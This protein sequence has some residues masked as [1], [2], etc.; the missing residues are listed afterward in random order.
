[1]FGS[2]RRPMLAALPL[3]LALA[4][5]ALPAH[6]DNSWRD[7]WCARGEGMSVVVDWA[8]APAAKPA[9]SQGGTHL[10]RCLRFANVSFDSSREGRAAPF[11]DIGVSVTFSNELV[12]SVNGIDSDD[13]GGDWM[14]AGSR[15]TLAWDMSI[16]DPTPDIPFFIASLTVE[17]PTTFSVEPQWGDPPSTR[18][19]PSPAPST[20]RPATTPT[21]TASASRPA[22]E[23]TARPDQPS[24]RH[25]PT[26]PRTRSARP[27][28]PRPTQNPTRAPRPAPSPTSSPTPTPSL[29]A[30]PSLT[31]SPSG[32]ATAEAKDVAMAAPPSPTPSAVWGAEHA[33]RAATDAP[34]GLPGWVLPAGIAGVLGIGGALAHAIVRARREGEDFDE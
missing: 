32:T 30:S 8:Q 3:T 11:D 4:P 26:A 27:T 29:E 22:P 34:E 14:F 10:V 18:P 19:S 2:F 33:E 5:L 31:P 13:F 6:A 12:D 21:A 1:M 9:I 24:P 17:P 15:D 16:W 28:A 20:T 7:G 23:P 25:T